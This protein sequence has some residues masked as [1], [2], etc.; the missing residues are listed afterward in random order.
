MLSLLANTMSVATRQD[1]WSDQSNRAARSDA[2]N[3]R[4]EIERKKRAYRNAG[5]R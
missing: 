1:R 4:E 3:E 5:I 2:Q